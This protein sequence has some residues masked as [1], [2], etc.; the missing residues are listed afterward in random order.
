MIHRVVLLPGMDGT[1]ELFA[2]FIESLPSSFRT[3]TV[4]YPTDTFLSYLELMPFVQSTIP[5]GEP[6]VLVA[7]S[8]STPL[9]IQFAAMNPPN[10]RGLV[11]CSG[12]V[13]SPVQGLLRHLGWLLAPIIFKI[14]LPEFVVR[15][16]LVGPDAPPSLLACVLN[17]VSS[18]QPEVLSARLRSVLDFDAR[19]ELDRVAVPI[20]YLQGGQDRLVP[21]S[22]VERI[23]KTKPPITVVKIAGPHLLFQRKPEQ[24]ADVVARFVEL[25]E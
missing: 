7:E 15:L 25:V 2:G 9:A 17:A 20:L 24:T 4:R 11:L 10:L 5:P 19:A 16:L 14:P 3:E 22:C 21:E 13:T 8:F 12:F 23:Q 1:G 18:V 6:F